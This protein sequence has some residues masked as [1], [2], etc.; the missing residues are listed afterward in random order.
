LKRRAE[1]DGKDERQIGQQHHEP[2]DFAVLIYYEVKDARREIG[3]QSG[4]SGEVESAGKVL[5]EFT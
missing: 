4:D 5:D 2:G 1:D 3:D